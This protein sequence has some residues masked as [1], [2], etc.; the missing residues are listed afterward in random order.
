MGSIGGRT[1]ETGSINFPF[2]GTIIQSKPKILSQKAF[3]NQSK[4]KQLIY[5]G[6]A[7]NEQDGMSSEDVMND[8]LSS[9]EIY[10]GKHAHGY[11]IYF[12][13]KKESALTKYAEN[14]NTILTAFINSKAKTITEIDLHKLYRKEV[15]KPKN[16][17]EMN[18]FALSKGYNVV[19]V[20]GG[21]S[22]SKNSVA[23]KGEKGEDYYIVLDKKVLTIRKP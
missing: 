12:T 17:L 19:K 14:E 13:T 21:P 18:A 8:T 6:I 10:K 2:K 22:S 5:R 7:P 23:N 11:G 16:N 9:S 20:E 1:E 4:G 15:G 3:D